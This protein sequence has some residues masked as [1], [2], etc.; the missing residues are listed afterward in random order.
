MSGAYT[1]REP[2]PPP[3]SPSPAKTQP[4]DTS[5]AFIGKG[6]NQGNLDEAKKRLFGSD[7][8]LF[9]VV[10]GT[11]VRVEHHARGRDD[12]RRLNGLL[13]ITSKRA[14]FY[15]TMMFGRYDQI[16]FPYDQISSVYC[17]KGMIGDELQLQV[18]SDRVTIHNIPKGE[19]DVA[20]QNIRDMV[21]T[22]KAQPTASVVV[23]AA[24]QIDIADQIEKL[25]KLR[26]K[27][28]ITNEEFERK[29]SELLSRL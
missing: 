18:A 27:G 23:S 14:M 24:P 10:H 16:V 20:A 4:M 17:H 7:E 13:L 15:A 9:C 11:A 28:L 5:G 1:G 3:P 25:G 19:G 8:K 29:R 6:V 12:V 2:P 26:E 22:M 21:G